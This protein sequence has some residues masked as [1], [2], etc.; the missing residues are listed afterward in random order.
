[1]RKIKWATERAT[2]KK[3]SKQGLRDAQKMLMEMNH[4]TSLGQEPVRQVCR[5]QSKA[6]W[7]AEQKKPEDKKLKIDLGSLIG[8]KL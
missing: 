8:K 7:Q 1:M 4:I 2:G 5:V 6:D 3:L